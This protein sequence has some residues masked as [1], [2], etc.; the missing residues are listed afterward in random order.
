MEDPIRAKLMEAVKAMGNPKKDK[1]ATVEHKGGGSHS[2]TY[3]QLDSVLAEVAPALAAQGLALSQ[4]VRRS[5]DGALVFETAVYD[6]TG[7]LV[8]D[9]RP[10]REYTDPQQQ[11]SWETYNRRYALL[12]VFG[13]AAE[14]DDGA[15]AKGAERQPSATNRANDPKGGQPEPGAQNKTPRNDLNRFTEIK[16]RLAAARGVSGKDA[17]AELVAAFGNPRGMSAEQYES[18]IRNATTYTA[19]VERGSNAGD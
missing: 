8:L 4:G 17:A 15:A 3:T 6:G 9:A 19:A 1:T 12:A 16:D 11:G 5:I 7:E 18:M 13:L 14:D 2:Y 10:Y